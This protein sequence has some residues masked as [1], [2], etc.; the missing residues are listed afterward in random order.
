MP[1]CPPRDQWDVRPPADLGLHAGALAAAIEY[2]RENESRWRRDFT[3]AS[4]RYIGVA[5][6]PP[7]DGD[8]LGLV[9]PRGGPNGL[10]LRHGAIAAEWGDTSR[11]DMTFSIAKSYLAVLAGLAVDRGLIRDLDEPVS[12]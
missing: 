8:V 3:I 7:A 5:D 12:S 11:V 6:D 1:Y 9:E 10:V 2:H 4:G